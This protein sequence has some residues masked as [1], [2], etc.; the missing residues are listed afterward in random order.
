MARAEVGA[1]G[2]LAQALRR[3]YAATFEAGHD[4]SEQLQDLARFGI[5]AVG[6]QNVLL[7]GLFEIITFLRDFSETTPTTRNP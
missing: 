2:G 3:L 1:F 5:D 4:L 6:G 7:L